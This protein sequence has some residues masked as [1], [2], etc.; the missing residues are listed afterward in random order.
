MTLKY[1]FYLVV[2]VALGTL[3]ALLAFVSF[4]STELFSAMSLFGSS[5]LLP[6][7]GVALW[8]AMTIRAISR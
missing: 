7:A 4:S 5:I 6:V 3:G 8:S 1:F 2:G